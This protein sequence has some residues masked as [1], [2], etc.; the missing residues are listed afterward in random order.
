MAV[1]RQFLDYILEM[2]APLGPVTGRRMFGGAGIFYETLMFAL[3]A[4][5]CLYFKVDDHTRAAFVDAGCGPFLYEKSGKVMEMAYF[6]APEYLYDDAE[7]LVK[8]GRD[9]VDVALR[10]KAKRT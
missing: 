6:E 2:L 9:A 4:D 3:I 1:S 8:W 7:A 5:E 10:A